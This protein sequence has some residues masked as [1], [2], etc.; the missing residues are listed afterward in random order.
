MWEIYKNFIFFIRFILGIIIIYIYR[1][2]IGSWWIIFGINL[3]GQ[4]IKYRRNLTTKAA[5][6][7]FI[8][9]SFFLHFF[10]HAACSFIPHT[11]HTQK[12]YQP[13]TQLIN[14][15]KPILVF[16]NILRLLGKPLLFYNW[17]HNI[18]MDKILYI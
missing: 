17:F 9:S 2:C 15:Y 14:N 13:I 12:E 10:S 11:M 4:P 18:G 8:S 16:P 3:R 7:L 1:L 6:T 5:F